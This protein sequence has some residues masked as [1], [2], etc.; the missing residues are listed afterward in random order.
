MDDRQ[1]HT[2]QLTH[3]WLTGAP[4]G[5][6]KGSSDGAMAVWPQGRALVVGSAVGRD[7]CGNLGGPS[8]GGGAPSSRLLHACATPWPSPPRPVVRVTRAVAPGEESAWSADGP[9]RCGPVAAPCSVYSY[10]PDWADA[11][12]LSSQAAARAAA[13][14]AALRVA[15]PQLDAGQGAPTGVGAADR[16]HGNSRREARSLV[17]MR[18]RQLV[19]W[20]PH[21]KRPKSPQPSISQNLECAILYAR[22]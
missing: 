10:H 9:R 13:R 1:G 21:W 2:R 12:R 18:P 20:P 22:Q 8:T 6:G 7:V 5:P 4:H 16:S 15:G 14:A 19:A 11:A 17:R 3:A